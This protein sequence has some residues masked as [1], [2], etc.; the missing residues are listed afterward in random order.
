MTDI[1]HY[2]KLYAKIDRSTMQVVKYPY[3]IHD[4]EES[5]PHTS[6]DDRFSLDEWY[7]MTDEALKST[8]QVVEVETD[9]EPEYDPKTQYPVKNDIPN[10]IDGNWIISWT[11]K[12]RETLL[13]QLGEGELAGT[14]PEGSTPI[15]PESTTPLETEE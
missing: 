5:N 12:E 11:I 4:L 15:P 2:N 3:T 1:K 8:T 6:Y 14:V 9:P 13:P 10:H 7:A